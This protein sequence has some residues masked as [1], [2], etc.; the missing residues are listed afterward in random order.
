[1]LQ[2]SASSL[3]D[4]GEPAGGYRRDG[5]RYPIG[6]QD[7]KWAMIESLIPPGKRRK[8]SGSRGG[9]ERA[10]NRLPVAASHIPLASRGLARSRYGGGLGL[11]GRLCL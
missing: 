11:G 5:L 9:D 7:E 3:V 1:V 6:L 8:C 10:G 4:C 2:G